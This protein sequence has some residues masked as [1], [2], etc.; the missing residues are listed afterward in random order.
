MR[1]FALV[2]LRVCL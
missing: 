1:I 2:Y